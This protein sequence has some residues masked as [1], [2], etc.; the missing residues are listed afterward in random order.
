LEVLE[1]RDENKL[2]REKLRAVSRADFF[3]RAASTYTSPPIAR[4]LAGITAGA[5][6]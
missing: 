1:L 6:A 2:L 3:T 4:S 5:G